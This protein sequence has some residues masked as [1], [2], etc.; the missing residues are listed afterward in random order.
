MKLIYKPKGAAG[1]Y[2]KYAVNFFNG[3]SNECAYCGG[4]VAWRQQTSP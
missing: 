3:C 4:L 1:E 2:A